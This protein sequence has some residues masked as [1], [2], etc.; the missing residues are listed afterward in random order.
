MS[1]ELAAAVGRGDRGD[2]GDDAA[3]ITSS[4]AQCPTV[5]EDQTTS[6]DDIYNRQE[7]PVFVPVQDRVLE[8]RERAVARGAESVRQEGP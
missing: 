3:E 7:R 5:A 2:R 6:F 8:E 4:P 1:T